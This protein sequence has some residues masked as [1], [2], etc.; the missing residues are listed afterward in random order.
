MIDLLNIF[1]EFDKHVGNY[2]M[3]DPMI[4]IKYYHSYRVMHLCGEIADDL[5]LNV[6]ETYLA[7]TIGLLHD[8]ARFEQWSKYKTYKDID[9]VDH[10]DLACNLLFDNNEIEKFN[11]DKKYHKVIYDAIKYHNK[12]SYPDNLNE[13]NKLFCEIIRDA[14]KLD[15]FYLCSI[16]DINLPT[17]DSEISDLISS[18]FYQDKL[19]KKED[20]KNLN[21]RVLLELAMIFDL[22]FKYSFKYLK[23]IKIMDSM[24]NKIDNKKKLEPYF[25]Y[26]KEIIEKR[27]KVYVR[28]KI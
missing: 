4:K 19:I 15:I 22:K 8:Y 14:D 27:E 16:G 1:D 11:I 5:N 21:E 3:S 7:M 9:S 25:K 26:A 10:G 12:Y 6:E 18:E 28:K 17:D 24:L 23:T 2:D 20:V 13:K